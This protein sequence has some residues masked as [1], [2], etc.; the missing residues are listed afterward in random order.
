MSI[1][2]T[3]SRTR[4]ALF[5]LG[6]LL[7]S[8][9][10]LTRLGTTVAS[11]RGEGALQAPHLISLTYGRYRPQG[12]PHAYLALRLTALEPHGQVVT[13]QIQTPGSPTAVADGGCDLG[14]RRNGHVAVFYM[15]FTLHAGV[16]EVTV[17]A[18]GAAC[19]SSTKT[20]SATRT[21]RITVR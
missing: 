6:L 11:A 10:G 13:T 16:H 7:A 5:G 21:F 15:P 12:A 14:G 1:I 3:S 2:T 17:T 18:T 8:V 20:R 9:L 4:T 19:S